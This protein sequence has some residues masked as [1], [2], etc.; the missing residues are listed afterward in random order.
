MSIAEE[1]A[2]AFNRQDVD[3]LLACFTT[4]ASYR[5]AL[6]GDHAGTE[7]LRGMFA[8]MFREGR[9]FD[10]SARPHP[11]VHRQGPR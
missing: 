8:R 1:F 7:S 3:A 5:D 11:G 10:A 6:C 9:D 2:A 4:G